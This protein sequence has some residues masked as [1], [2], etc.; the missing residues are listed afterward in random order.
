[1]A[2]VKAYVPI[3]PEKSATPIRANHPL[4]DNFGNRKCFIPTTAR[5]TKP[6]ACSTVTI[7]SGETPETFE[8]RSPSSPQHTPA[9]MIQIKDRFINY[10]ISSRF[11]AP[12]GAVIGLVSVFEVMSNVKIP[13]NIAPPLT[14]FFRLVTTL[15]LF[16]HSLLTENVIKNVTFLSIFSSSAISWLGNTS[17]FWR[18][19]FLITVIKALLS[20]KP[21]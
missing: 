12:T 19:I 5:I 13:F 10:S 21:L 4:V 2:Q 7:V 3:R 6:I 15:I 20:T 1:M 11:L 8:R 14:A 17:P 16:I 9:K 18:A